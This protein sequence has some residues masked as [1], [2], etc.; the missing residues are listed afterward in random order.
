[1]WPRFESEW[2]YFS[3]MRMWNV[4][5]K[6][7]CNKHLL[8]EHVEMHMCAGSLD[9]RK[10]VKG[11]IEGGLIEVHNISKRHNV[12]AGEMKRSVMNHKSQLGFKGFKAGKVDVSK[13]ERNLI[14]R[15]SE[16]GKNFQLYSRGHKS[17]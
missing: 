9:R 12:L 7:M 10:S 17:F 14:E 1:M 6:K 13:S 5:V 3:K 15:C 16:C 4:N 8:G 2:G 11:F